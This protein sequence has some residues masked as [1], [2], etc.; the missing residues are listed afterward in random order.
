[1]DQ[2]LLNGYRQLLEDLFM[3]MKIMDTQRNAASLYWTRILTGELNPKPLIASKQGLPP[4]METMEA[5]HR[6]GYLAKLE[7][8][9]PLWPM[10]FQNALDS[11]LVD[12]EETLCLRLEYHP[13]GL[14]KQAAKEADVPEGLF[15]TGKLSMYFDDKNN[16]IVGDE[17]I[18]ADD[19]IMTTQKMGASL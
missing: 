14:L 19:F 10:R 9:N 16:I 3:R 12:A 6:K 15:P 2:S 8:E 4:F 7:I 5:M 1:M 18:N 17:K 13:E 11:L